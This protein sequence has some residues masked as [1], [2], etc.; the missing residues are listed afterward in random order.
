MKKSHSTIKK[1]SRRRRGSA[2]LMALMYT[3]LF[4]TLAASMTLFTSSNVKVAEAN[5]RQ[6]RADA[7]AES[8]MSFLLFQIRQCP[9]PVT[10]AGT[11][12][13]SL[14]QSLWGGTNG[15]ANKIAN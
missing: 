13:S 7:A 4:G 15:I 14:A 5:D 3:T 10:S 1:L 12:S 6:V 9:K 11:I 2:L 8:G